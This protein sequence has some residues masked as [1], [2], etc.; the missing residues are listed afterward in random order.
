[1]LGLYDYSRPKSNLYIPLLQEYF[2]FLHRAFVAHK[3]LLAAAP[4]CAISQRKF[5]AATHRHGS[6]AYEIGVIDTSI[7]LVQQF[8]RRDRT[9]GSVVLPLFVRKETDDLR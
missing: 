7:K 1:M 4:P 5:A 6:A 3:T 2:F 8:F 9:M